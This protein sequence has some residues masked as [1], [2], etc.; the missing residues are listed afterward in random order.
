MML[1]ELV[2]VGHNASLAHQRVIANLIFHLRLMLRNGQ[3]T[4]DALPE[5]DLDTGNPQSVCPDIVLLDNDAFTFPVI[6]EVTTN[7][8]F[9]NDCEKVSRLVR[10]TKFGIEEA[11]VYNFQANKWFRYSINSGASDSSFSQRL[12]IDLSTFIQS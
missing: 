7:Y 3:T 5:T 4:L 9:R 11:F 12:N 6:I 8:G 1:K 2:D 10:E